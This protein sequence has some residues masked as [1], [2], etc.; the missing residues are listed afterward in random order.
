[1]NTQYSLINY[2]TILFHLIKNIW[3]ILSFQVLL[4][5]VCIYF[6]WYFIAL[7]F[8]QIYC[9][10]FLISNFW[11][12]ITFFISILGYVLFYRTIYILLYFML[13][14]HMVFIVYSK[15]VASCNTFIHID[16]MLR[17]D[18]YYYLGLSQHSFMLKDAERL[19]G[20]GLEPMSLGWAGVGFHRRC[21]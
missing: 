10:L 21:L 5:V 15:Y 17:L 16:I 13:F 1:M 8:D 3:Y 12:Y 18:L 19:K 14:K 20:E 2:N 11:I 7:C 6:C 4:H 9:I